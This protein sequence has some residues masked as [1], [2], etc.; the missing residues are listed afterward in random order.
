M[1]KNQIKKNLF[2]LKSTYPD[3]YNHC[4][5]MLGKMSADKVKTKQNYSNEKNLKSSSHTHI[6]DA[7]NSLDINEKQ[8]GI[9][10]LG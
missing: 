9:F 2:A 4:Q 8:A 10:L 6:F 1:D 5:I 7:I 3:A